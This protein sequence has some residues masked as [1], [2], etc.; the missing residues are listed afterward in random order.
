MRNISF[1]F[2][3]YLLMM[4]NQKCFPFEVAI[5]G[6]WSWNRNPN[7]EEQFC[8][9]ISAPQHCP[10]GEGKI[11]I[12]WTE[13]NFLRLTA[14]NW[15]NCR[16]FVSNI[17]ILLKTLEKLKAVERIFFRLRL[18]ILV[19]LWSCLSVVLL[20]VRNNFLQTK[21]WEK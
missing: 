6:C 15:M 10:R 7:K 19:L 17:E 16:Q 4:S 8:E 2:Y 12:C 13:S 1:G 20:W 14:S 3:F 5:K 21:T 18:L 11:C 9:L